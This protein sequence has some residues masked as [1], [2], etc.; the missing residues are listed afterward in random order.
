MLLQLLESDD[1]ER[2]L[3]GAFKNDFGG[4]GGF[5]SFLKAEGAKTPS[6]PRAE[7]FKPK[8]LLWGGK[9]IASFF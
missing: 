5:I 6:I 1:I 2:T 8:G 7:P 9:V 3:M 4:H